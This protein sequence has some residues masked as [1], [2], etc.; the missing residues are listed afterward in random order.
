M[1]PVTFTGSFPKAFIEMHGIK[2]LNAAGAIIDTS[3][4][5]YVRGRSMKLV[6]SGIFSNT[7]MMSG[8]SGCF[9]GIDSLYNSLASITADSIGF[10]SSAPMQTSSNMVQTGVTAQS[11]M[12][13][14]VQNTG[15][16]AAVLSDSYALLLDSHGT[17]LI[18]TFVS[19][20]PATVAAGST[21]IFST[22]VSYS[23]IYSNAKLFADYEDGT[24]ANAKI[25]ISAAN[26]FAHDAP[27]IQA[28]LFARDKQE[29]EKA[30]TSK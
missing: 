23:G 2:Y 12:Q 16:L 15:T 24:S 28:L 19:P 14:A 25:A 29:H 3:D 20:T 21:G 10:S 26:A 9:V 22:S 6:S 30:E 18:W 4:F 5:T 27:Q 13:I 11:T 17:P 1:L 7:C 8:D